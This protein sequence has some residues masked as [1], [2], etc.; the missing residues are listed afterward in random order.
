MSRRVKKRQL[1]TNHIKALFT[2]KKNID[3]RLREENVFAE[4][5]TTLTLDE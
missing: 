5:I 2:G 1:K 3:H 4:S